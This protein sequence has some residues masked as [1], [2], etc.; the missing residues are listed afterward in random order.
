ML[1]SLIYPKVSR[2]GIQHFREHGVEVVV[3]VFEGGTQ[4]WET[5]I[6]KTTQGRLFSFN[7]IGFDRA[8]PSYPGPFF[9]KRVEDSS[10][11]THG[12]A[13]TDS[14]NESN[15]LSGIFVNCQ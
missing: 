13:V 11:G 12:L 6:K 9:H 14:I 3:G 1:V 15:N 10:H 2:K 5:Q 4:E 7:L 8:G